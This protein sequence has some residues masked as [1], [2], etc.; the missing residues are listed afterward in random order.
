W[1]FSFWSTI[2]HHKHDVFLSFRGEDTRHGLAEELQSAL[3]EAGIPTYRDNV[4][5]EQGKEIASELMKAIQMSR[6]AIIIFSRNYATSSWC[7]DE[8]VKILECKRVDGRVVLPVFCDVDPDDVRGQVGPF[9]EAFEER[10]L[11]SSETAPL[12]QNKVEKWREALS[13]ASSLSGFDLQNF[14]QW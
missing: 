14:H 9:G 7:L 4:N 13:E 10:F 1:S 11:K 8:L 5:L 3:L 2:S 6:V 12:N